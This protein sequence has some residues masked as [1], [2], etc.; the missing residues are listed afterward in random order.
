MTDIEGIISI[1]DQAGT[2][3]RHID[4]I[5]KVGIA[6]CRAAIRLLAI[7]DLDEVEKR[8]EAAQRSVRLLRSMR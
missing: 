6:N 1:I 4:Q 7:D 3:Q 5:K 8:L 2:Q